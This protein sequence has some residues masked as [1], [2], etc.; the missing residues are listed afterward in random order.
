MKSVLYR[1]GTDSEK[2]KGEEAQAQT[3]CNSYPDKSG[4]SKENKRGK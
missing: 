4:K 3:I 1:N 2:R